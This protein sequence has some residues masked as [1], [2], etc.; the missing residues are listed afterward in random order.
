MRFAIVLVLL[1]C[2]LFSV[3]S[4]DNHESYYGRPIR[5]IEFS[6]LHNIRPADLEGISA[7][8]IGRIYTPELGVLLLDRIV[9]QDFFSNDPYPVI[10]PYRANPEGTEVILRIHVTELP[11]VSRI[12]FIGNNSIRRNDLLELIISRVGDPSSLVKLRMD[13]QAIQAR[14]IER[15][16]G[17]VSVSSEESPGPNNSIIINFTIVEGRRTVIEEFIFEGNTIFTSRTL[18]RQLSSS[19][20]TLFNDGAFQEAKLALDRQALVQYYHDRGYID[21]HLVD[22]ITQ[23]RQDDNENQLMTIT[24][25]LSEGQPYIFTGI[26]F[27]GNQVFSDETLSSLVQSRVGDRVNDRRLQGDLMR[28]AN[29]YFENGYIFNTINPIPER[30]PENLTLSYNVIINEMNRAHI[31]SIVIV[32]NERTQDHVILREIPLEPGDIF[33]QGKVM[34]GLRNLFNLQYFS[35]V[36]PEMNPGSAESL[37]ELVINVEEMLTSDIR[38]GLTFSGSAEPGAFPISAM[39]TW[40]DRNFRGGGDA[41]GADLTLSPYMQSISL[42]YTQRWFMGLPLSVSYELSLQHSSRRAALNNTSPFFHGDEDYAYPD[43]FNSWEEYV[44]ANRTPP[45]EFIMTYSNWRIGLGVSTGYRW[46]TNLGLLGLGGGLQ[47]GLILNSFDN[48]LYRPFSPVLREA[49]NQWRP[50]VSIFTSLSLDRRDIFYDPSSGLY[51][52]QRASIT[53]IFPEEYEYHIRTDTRVQWFFTLW[54]L[55]VTDNWN[56]KA[57]LGLHTGLSFIFSQPWRDAPIIEESNRLALDGMFIGRGWGYDEFN[58]KGLAMWESWAE[59]RI[60]LVRGLLSWD[61]FFDAAGVKSTPG[62]L[63]TDFMTPDNKDLFFLRFSWGGGVR[64]TIPMF[65]LR[66][67]LARRFAVD[68]SGNIQHYTRGGGLGGF[69]FIVSFALSSF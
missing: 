55:Y 10:M 49:N 14:Y 28:I 18:Q 38:F 42:G 20:R 60:P 13:M 45:D 56:F 69:D 34:D 22:V 8:F 33:S 35:M 64:F 7:A 51:I 61:F 52:S 37:M 5:R 1:V 46:N 59:V 44:A 21:A 50:A 65:P 16:F 40:N 23:I 67:S 29:L 41:I 9:A 26:T 63:F 4:Q 66:F 39:V 25:V 57:V 48:D 36:S 27:Q 11:V 12:N 54:D 58:N 43:G 2:T 31:E 32:G 68:S 24:F 17:A 15:G 6:G 30:N 62:E 3:F 47:F 19:T 53:G